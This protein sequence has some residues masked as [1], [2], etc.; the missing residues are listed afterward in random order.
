MSCIGSAC[1]RVLASNYMRPACG[2]AKAMCTLPTG[3][4][5]KALLRRI[6]FLHHDYVYIVYRLCACIQLQLVHAALL[7]SGMPPSLIICT[8]TCT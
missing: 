5:Y 4:E 1:C 2:F 3:S 7:S 6:F 8:C